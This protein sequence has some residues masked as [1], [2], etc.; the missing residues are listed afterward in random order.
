MSTTSYM[1]SEDLIASVERRAHI[2]ESQVTFTDDD[3]LAFANE[4]MMVG[5]VPAVLQFHEEFF[6]YEQFIPIVEYTSKY[7][8][9][10]RA[11]GNKVRSMFFLDQVGQF[12][13]PSSPPSSQ[14]FRANL[15]EM[16]RILPEDKAFYYNRSVINYPNT[17]CLENNSIVLVP[18]IEGHPTGGLLVGYFQ[19]PNQLV[20]SDQIATVQTIDLTTGQV[21][22]DQIPTEFGLSEPV[23]FLQTVGGHKTLG[24]DV[25]PT[26]I[27]VPLRT[28][29]FPVG[30][31]PYKLSVGD[32]IALAG[33]TNIP[34][35]PDELHT[36]LAQRVACRC[37]EAQGDQV[38]LQA[39][40]MKLQEME[41]KMGS[42][43][44]N[45]TEGNPQK[46]NNLR[47]ALREAKIK[48]RRNIY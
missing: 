34:Q 25:T 37:L 35:V 23:D 19:R 41:V 47:G 15:R 29:T 8:V 42:L 36:V 5:L 20:T 3:L 31:V 13:P 30:Y 32:T 28:I 38:G 48:R 10:Y 6:V 9:P 7:D 4:E 26:G 17:F 22:V 2:P 16:A 12:L 14:L 1:T 11:I 18:E 27:S 44:D 40:N 24:M 39:A 43:I 45:R 46:V 21:V 33:T